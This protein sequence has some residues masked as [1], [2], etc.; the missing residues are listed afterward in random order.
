MKFFVYCAMV[1]LLVL[2]TGVSHAKA[3]VVNIEALV[4]ERTQASVTLADQIWQLAELGYQESRSSEALQ[5][6][7]RD[8]GF[9]VTPGVA[10]IPT[11]F[12]A[13]Y[14]KGGPTIGILAE[15]D[16][17]PGLSQSAVPYRE[18]RIPDAPGHACGH[19]LFGSASA[20]AG[21]ALA[22]WIKA[23]SVKP[24]SRYLAPRLKKAVRVRSIWLARGCL[25]MW[26]WFCIGTRVVATRLLHPPPPPTSRGA[27]PSMVEPPM[28]LPRRKKVAQR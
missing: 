15:F 22:E 4:K 9:A 21:V 20:T 13:A 12:V 19:H 8:A 28:P 14:G 1:M 6:Y 26:M 16:A 17:L 23:N 5:D 25:T 11:A 27:S 18:P 2:Q 3:S 24:P 10:D 7:L